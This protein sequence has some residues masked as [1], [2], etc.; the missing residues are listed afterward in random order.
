MVRVEGTVAR[1]VTGV[2]AAPFL[3]GLTFSYALGRPPVEIVIRSVMTA[4]VVVCAV[5]S[6]WLGV[7]IGDDDVLAR[8]WLRRL[9]IP[10][11][12]IAGCSS[13][14]YA[15]FFSKGS[16]VLWLREL[17]LRTS[18]HRIDQLG[19]TVAFVA[20]SRLQAEQINSSARA[21][22]SGQDLS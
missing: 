9:R 2:F 12:K 19:G 11:D 13:E 8:T 16:R 15:G 6:W 17:E 22:R 5:R 10:R 20:R 3:L 7:W 14:P 18:D 21:Y 4:L 1:I